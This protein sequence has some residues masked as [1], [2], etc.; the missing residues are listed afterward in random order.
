MFQAYN[1]DF[2]IRFV[3]SGVYAVHPAKQA[4]ATYNAGNRMYALRPDDPSVNEDDTYLEARGWGKQQMK[5]RKL[6]LDIDKGT[7]GLHC[8][9]PARGGHTSPSLISR[10]TVVIDRKP[11]AARPVDRQHGGHP[12]GTPAPSPTWRARYGVRRC[13]VRALVCAT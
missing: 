2:S 4:A 10:A 13:G 12:I 9:T 6:R 11:G 5:K 1:V 3:H 8:T 7:Q